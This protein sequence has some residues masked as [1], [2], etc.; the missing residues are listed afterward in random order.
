MRL[1]RSCQLQLVA[2][3]RRASSIGGGFGLEVSKALWYVLGLLLMFSEAIDNLFTIVKKRNYV[4]DHANN[5]QCFIP[6]HGYWSIRAVRTAAR[7]LTS[8]CFA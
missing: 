2:W 8:L 4:G 7:R 6:L 1:Y 3:S 5:D